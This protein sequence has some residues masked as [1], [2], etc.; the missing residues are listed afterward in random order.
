MARKLI[1]RQT[2][3]LVL[4]LLLLASGTPQVLAR[5]AAQDAFLTDARNNTTTNTYDSLGNLIVTEDPL[6]GITE[7]TYDSR[8]RMT[9]AENPLHQTET[10]D[11]DAVTGT[12]TTW[13]DRRG[14]PKYHLTDALGSVRGVNGVRCLRRRAREHRHTKPVC[15]HRRAA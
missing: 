4:S 2:V 10:W 1:E 9:S 11:Y 15:L 5:D 8:G 7:Y 14:N 3:V 12:L 6:G 13:T